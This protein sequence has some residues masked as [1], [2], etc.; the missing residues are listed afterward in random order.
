MFTASTYIINATRSPFD[1]IV[2][3]MTTIENEW[4]NSDSATKVAKGIGTIFLN[5]SASDDA[6]INAVKKFNNLSYKNYPL[7]LGGYNSMIT[8]E[9]EKAYKY[10]EYMQFK[11]SLFNSVTNQIEYDNSSGRIT[12]M[13]FNFDKIY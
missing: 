4:G 2:N 7:T 13:V 12:K 10:Y 8:N 11:R 9:K 5:N 6:K 1:T 3:S